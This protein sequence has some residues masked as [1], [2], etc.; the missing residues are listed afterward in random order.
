MRD[1]TSTSNGMAKENEDELFTLP[2]LS[3][4]TRSVSTP[5]E[6]EEII[7]ARLKVLGMT[8][9]EYVASL[10]AYDCWAEKPHLLTGEQCRGHRNDKQAREEERRMWAEI[11]ADFGKVDKADKPGSYFAHRAAEI[12]R[13][14]LDG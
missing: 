10:I 9:Q 14:K 13:Q 3:R 7:K 8:F 5:G 12:M 1:R 6:A 2:L 4:V 11:G